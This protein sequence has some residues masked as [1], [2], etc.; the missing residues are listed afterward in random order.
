VE[1]HI[2]AWERSYLKRG[3]LWAGATKGLPDLPRGSKVLEVGC[4]S[5][6]TLSSMPRGWKATAVDVSQEAIKMARDLDLDNLQCALSDA[7][8]L[9]FRKETFDAVLAFHVTG[10]V[11][12]EDRKKMASELSRVL[13]P[14]GRL[15]FREFELQDMRCGKGRELEPGTFQRGEGVVTHYFSQD[16]ARELFLALDSVFVQARRWKMRV[17]GRDLTR[18]ELEAEFVKPEDHMA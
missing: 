1:D 8:R 6:K 12:E 9:P 7:R 5:G 3:R 15:F 10:H 18:S 13:K 4:G 16:E 14:S 17:R 2:K 11:L